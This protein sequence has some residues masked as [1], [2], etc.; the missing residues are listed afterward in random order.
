MAPSQ[1]EPAAADLLAGLPQRLDQVFRPW[2]KSMPRQPALI[3]DGNVWSYGALPG[4][5]TTQPRSYEIMACD[6]AIA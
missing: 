3:G 5:V 4:I 6:R 1:V 2:A